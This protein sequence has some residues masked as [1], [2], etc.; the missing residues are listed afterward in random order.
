MRKLAY[1]FLLLITVCTFSSCAWVSHKNFEKPKK[2]T[3]GKEN[4][5]SPFGENFTKAMF[6]TRLRYK[7]SYFSGI[8]LIKRVGA[9]HHRITFLN[10]MG[11]KLMDLEFMPKSFQVHHCL[12][13][14]N[15]KLLIATLERDLRLL[16]MQNLEGKDAKV[17]DDLC[18][19]RNLYRMKQ[20]EGVVYYFQDA[21]AVTRIETAA[22]LPVKVTLI[23][24]AFREGF[25]WKVVIDHRPVKLQITL[26]RIK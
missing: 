20:K 23:L 8:V 5:V 4:L 16:L 9:G 3:I 2:V 18:E 12:E 6:K 13:A 10:E 25:P 14:L 17:Y 26:E 22:I 11:L 24:S 19:S 1:L 21:P 15:R 7:D